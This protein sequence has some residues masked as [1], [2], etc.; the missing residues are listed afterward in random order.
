MVH[1]I[2]QFINGEIWTAGMYYDPLNISIWSSRKSQDFLKRNLYWNK[3]YN[4]KFGCIYLELFN[5]S[6]SRQDD[7]RLGM[8]NCTERKP[9]ICEAIIYIL[10]V[11]K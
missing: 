2:G 8:A 11:L 6:K 4:K 7:P 3:I 5:D 10:R 1:I 9:F